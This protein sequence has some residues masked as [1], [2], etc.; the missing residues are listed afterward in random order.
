MEIE[1]QTC[2]KQRLY[3]GTNSVTYKDVNMSIGQG[4]QMA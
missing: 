4:D 1:L 3:L 2:W